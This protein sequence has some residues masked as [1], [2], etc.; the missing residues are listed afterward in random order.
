MGT[1]TTSEGP[2]QIEIQ[3]VTY[4]WDPSRDLMLMNGMAVAALLVESTLAGMMW[5]IERMVGLERF[6]LAMQAA[7]RRSIEDEWRT[8]I[9]QM[10]TPEEGIR[11]LG[12]LTPLG[13]LGRW[14]VVQFD[15]AARLGVF[16]V[17]A[18]FEPIYQKA[19][20]V[21]WGS[22]FLAGK[23]AGYC[24]NAFGVHCWAEQT[25]F[26]V[27]GDE[28]DEFTVRP[29]DQRVE[30]R[31]DALLFA[32]TASGPDLAAA[33]ERLRREVGERREAEARMAREIAERRA[34]EER[35]LAEAD[36]RRRVEDELLRKLE[37]IER[38][39]DDIQ[40][41]STPILQV[42]AHVLAVPIVGH[43]DGVRAGRLMEALLGAI[44]TRRAR[45][46]ILDLTGAEGIDTAALDHLLQLARAIGLLGARCMISGM[47]PRA[48]EIAAQLGVDLRALATY[49]TLEDALQAALSAGSRAR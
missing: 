46:A 43:L 19:L 45:V 26:A 20:A 14:Q 3:G 18:G 13:G 11:I 9:S 49:A 16:R 1:T 24:S 28:C 42:W 34:V 4:T 31:L 48:A 44:V 8:F 23:F 41:M 15:H 27:R 25:R 22:S 12:S 47:S 5:G 35:L 2:Q 33:L 7:G 38:Q 29:S 6:T 21:E 37:V 32:G 40:A 36:E 17:T 30:D 10:P 39:A